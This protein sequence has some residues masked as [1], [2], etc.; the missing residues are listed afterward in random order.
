MAE[1]SAGATA[2]RLDFTLT[3]DKNTSPITVHS[4]VIS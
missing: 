4:S 3:K 2:A 1:E